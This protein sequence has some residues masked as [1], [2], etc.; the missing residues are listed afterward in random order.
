MPY[1][2]TLYKKLNRAIYE[3]NSNLFY[4]LCVLQICPFGF[5]SQY[6]IDNLVSLL[7]H[8]PSYQA[9]IHYVCANMYVSM[10]YVSVVSNI[11]YKLSYALDLTSVNAFLI[12]LFVYWEKCANTNHHLLLGFP[13]TSLI[14]ITNAPP[15]LS[16]F[17]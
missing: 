17:K 15:P 7:F 13:R 10:S 3:N 6:S 1:C 11:L 9:F 14:H 16:L 4:F 8:S 5:L 12:S 2:T